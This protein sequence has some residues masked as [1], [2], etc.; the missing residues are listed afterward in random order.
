MIKPI[1]RPLQ[2]D[3]EFHSATLL[4]DK[5]FE[6]QR[7]FPPFDFYKDKPADMSTNTYLFSRK[8]VKFELYKHYGEVKR[9]FLGV[10]EDAQQ[11]IWKQ[12]YESAAYYL[13]YLIQQ[14]YIQRKPYE[15]LIGI[16]KKQKNVEAEI[17]ILEVSISF[18]TE[19]K[20]KQGTRIMELAAMHDLTDYILDQ[21]ADKKI[22][23]YGGA[24]VL[25]DPMKFLDKWKARLIHLVS[26]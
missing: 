1:T 14:R 19:L 17:R 26:N 18:F 13:E 23:Y 4:G 5:L 20:A 12:D 2:Y 8:P 9:W 7:D 10:I 15:M 11:S 22:E 6:L 3:Y 25:Y 24:F 16:Y 21:G